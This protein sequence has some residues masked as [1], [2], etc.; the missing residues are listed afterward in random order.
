MGIQKG[1][2]WKIS[3]E[4]THKISYILGTIHIG[5]GDTMQL[6]APCYPLLEQCQYYYGEMDLDESKSLIDASFYSDPTGIPL[7]V[8]LGARKYQRI[9]KS[10]LHFL[11]LDLDAMKGVSAFFILSQLQAQMIQ[12]VGLPMDLQL[13]EKARSCGMQLGGIERVQDQIHV[14]NRIEPAHQLKQL[15]DFA[16]NIP[17]ARKRVETLLSLY[18]KEEILQIMLKT[19]SQLGSIKNLMLYDRNLSMAEF[20]YA[21]KNQASFYTLGA[22]HLAGYKGVLRH[23]KNRGAQLKCIPLVNNYQNYT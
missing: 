2:L 1:V 16:S 18:L 14:M 21:N 3:Y 10:V 9:R 13:W 8:Q 7:E 20:I 17:D 22:A 19:R 6:I 12:T 4:D 15:A 11:K 23:I 5:R